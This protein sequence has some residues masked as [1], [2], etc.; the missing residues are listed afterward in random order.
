[1][2]R[3]YIITIVDLRS[4]SLCLKKLLNNVFWRFTIKLINLLQKTHI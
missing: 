1:M 4:G 2:K 3:K